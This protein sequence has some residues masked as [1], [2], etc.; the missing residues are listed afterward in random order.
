MDPQQ[1]KI[2][3]QTLGSETVLEAVKRNELEAAGL[4]NRANTGGAAVA[5]AESSADHR[6]A[7]SSPSSSVGIDSPPGPDS[8]HLTVCAPIT[9]CGR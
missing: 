4:L 1:V 9:K 3:E 7:L 8:G 2:L 5:A 6:L